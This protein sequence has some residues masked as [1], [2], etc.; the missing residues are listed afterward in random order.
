MQSLTQLDRVL[1]VMESP[2]LKSE[3]DVYRACR[4]F[5]DDG[6]ELSWSELQRDH[7]CGFEFPHGFLDSDPDSENRLTAYLGESQSGS[8]ENF[9]RL[10]GRLLELYGSPLA[11][12]LDASETRYAAWLLER[13]GSPLM[14]RT[15]KKPAYLPRQISASKLGA[16]LDVKSLRFLVLNQ[17]HHQEIC[18]DERPR[19]LSVL[20]LVI[21]DQ[22][23]VLP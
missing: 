1:A 17:S 23:P 20:R 16:S 13:A 5:Q 12:L 7:D 14:A 2:N 9:D 8:S 10:Y 19:N 22:P 3:G 6:S 4:R 18:G 15:V 21:S 11:E